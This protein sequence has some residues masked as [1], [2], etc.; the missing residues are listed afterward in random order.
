MSS[1]F[2]RALE[3]A[4]IVAKKL[5]R[6][7]GDEYELCL[8]D[9]FFAVSRA[10][11]D[12]SPEKAKLESYLTQCIT[13]EVLDRLR[14]KWRRADRL[15]AVGSVQDFGISESHRDSEADELIAR[16]L[17]KAAQGKQVRTIRAEL[18]QELAAEGWTKNRISEAFSEISDLVSSRKVTAVY[19]ESDN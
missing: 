6:K 16:A 12:Y 9:A 2:N 15:K 7:Y 4:Q 19:T 14:T 17:E 10:F 5:A 13:R 8:S 1:D 11:P 3:I 18:R